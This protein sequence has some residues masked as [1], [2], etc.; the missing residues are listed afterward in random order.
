MSLINSSTGKAVDSDS[1]SG[2]DSYPSG[3]FEVS[4]DVLRAS[5]AQVATDEIGTDARVTDTID[6]NT[7]VVEAVDEATGSEVTG[8]TDLSGTEFTYTARKL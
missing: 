3:G 4:T 1:V 8:G 5:A 7:L 6:S 2:P